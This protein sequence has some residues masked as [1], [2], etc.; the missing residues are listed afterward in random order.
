ME[1]LGVSEDRIENPRNSPQ[2]LAP[3]EHSSPGHKTLAN[4][5]LNNKIKHKAVMNPTVTP[6]HGNSR[7]SQPQKRGEGHIVTIVIWDL[8][9]I[10]GDGDGD[11]IFQDYT[12]TRV[13]L[14]TEERTGGGGEAGRLTWKKPGGMG[15]PGMP[16][17][18]GMLPI[19][20][21]GAAAAL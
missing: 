13:E 1:C 7:L 3:L 12:T 5:A 18:G 21:L 11:A 14:K 4:L 19:T 16:S 20:G 15:P 2:S 6:P 10:P 8:L 9:E 17:L